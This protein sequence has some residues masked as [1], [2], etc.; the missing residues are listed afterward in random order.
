MTFKRVH[1]LGGAGSGKT[2]LA[3]QYARRRG[4]HHHELDALYYAD[5]P[6]RLR[7]KPAEREERLAEILGD[8][9]WVLEG[10]FWQPWIKP[11]LARAD[12][13][14]VLAVP[15]FVRHAR[16]VKRQLRLLRGA[17]PS[18]W[19]TFFP[20]LFELLAHNR[21]YH[22]GPLQETL[23]LLRDYQAKVDVCK[24][25]LAAERLLGLHAGKM[26]AE[27]ALLTTQLYPHFNHRHLEGIMPHFIAD[28]DWPNGMTGG[29]VVGL[30][31]IRRY[32]TQ[33]WSVINSQVTPISY[34]LTDGQVILE[35]HQL[36]RDMR[37]KQLSEG[38]VYHVYR[39]Q[40]GKIARMDIAD[41]L[42]AAGASVPATML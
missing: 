10:I 28:A 19:S 30:A 17:S 24:T 36:V 7:R 41:G 16:V 11:A 34:R 25:N 8:E 27:V 29:R 13:I 2:T 4:L 20:T 39:F 35:V 5:V 14:I 38:V 6:S 21:G 40:G 37:G 42:P 18:E 32:W 23:G 9:G 3:N 33:Q 26:E 1:I 22:R 31:A 12:K 15:E